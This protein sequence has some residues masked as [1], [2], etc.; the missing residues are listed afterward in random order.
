MLA[1]VGDQALGIDM[2][3]SG[4][5]RAV[6][7]CYHAKRQIPADERG[8]CREHKFLQSRMISSRSFDLH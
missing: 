8:V 5:N 3:L 6:E 1:L 4:C 2:V 7:R